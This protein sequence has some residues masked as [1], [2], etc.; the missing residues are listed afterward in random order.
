MS[1]RDAYVAIA[2]PTRREILG[3]LRDRGR[4][5]AGEIAA[6]FPSASRPGISRHLRVLRECGVVHCEREGKN[7]SGRFHGRHP[8]WVCDGK[9][10]LPFSV[11]SQRHVTATPGSGR[12]PDLRGASLVILND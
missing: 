1:T 6:R 5:Q 9:G 11:T 10:T 7:P 2:D 8:W 4:L 3:M 12:A